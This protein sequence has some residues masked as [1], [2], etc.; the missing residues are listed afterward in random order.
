MAWGERP[1]MSCRVAGA[2]G[3]NVCGTGFGE[4]AWRTEPTSEPIKCVEKVFELSKNKAINK[5]KQTKNMRMVDVVRASPVLGCCSNTACT[6][7]Y[8][9]RIV[10]VFVQKGTSDV[11]T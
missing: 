8:L 5:H 1:R 11:D 6:A 10:N 2:K 4:R 7:G 3:N 9:Q